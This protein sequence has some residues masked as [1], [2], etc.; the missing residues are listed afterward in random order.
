MNSQTD[1]VSHSP[2][3]TASLKTFNSSPGKPVFLLGLDFGS[4][5]SSALVASAN[6]TAC[7]TT[8]RMGFTDISICYRSESVFTPFINKT[9]DVVKV[10]SLILHWLAQSKVAISA[11]FS[12]GS[13][14]TGLAAQAENASVLTQ[15]ITQLVGDTIIASADEPCLESWLAFMGSCS[16]LSRIHENTYILN[17]DI[18]GGTTN[19]AMGINGNVIDTGCYFIGARHF[20]FIP[21]SYKLESL[22]AYGANLLKALGMSHKIG[23]TLTQEQCK[24]ILAFYVSALEAI[25]LGDSDF[26]TDSN[27]KMHQ[28]V[29]IQS[30]HIISPK[31][32]FSGGVAELLYNYSAGKTM[33]STTY[34]GDFGIDLAIAIAN[35]ALLSNNL[36]TFAPENKGRAT[37]YGLT[38]HSTEISGHTIYLPNPDCIPLRD[39]PIIAKLALNMSSEQWRNAFILAASRE[40]GSCIQIV[41]INS[42]LNT[43]NQV[44][45]IAQKIKDCITSS[46]LTTNQ[47]LV[48]LVE[49]N[50]G[51][52]LGNY[53]SDWGQS[54]HN[55]IV[56]DEVPLRN[57][58]F[59]NLGRLHQQMIPISFFGIH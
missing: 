6:I 40:Q 32:T 15:L 47:P 48:I 14:I 26:F 44:R 10:T 54:P 52:T 42:E 35:S 39:L 38:L 46:G 22:S 27:A 21:G 3:D 2:I 36:D 56:I 11:I 55:I 53:I 1:N 23:D 30:Q 5:T 37:V 59:V 12:G 58:H 34:F 20:Q 13:I 8:G 7:S 43:L 31:I 29:S 9:I 18:G 4:T 17:L 51:K 25:V 45:S 16:T 41:N 49:A 28:Q 33:P 24:E 57:A 19:V 50:I